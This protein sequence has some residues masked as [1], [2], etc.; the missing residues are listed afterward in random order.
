[1][2]IKKTLLKN[3]SLN[4]AGYIYLTIASFIS[5]PILLRNMGQELYGVYLLFSGIIPLIATLDFG[6]GQATIRY[7][8]LP[9]NNTKRRSSIWQTSFTSFFLVGLLVALIS[10]TF[11]SF[12]AS[13]LTA[14]SSLPSFQFLPLSIAISLILL[15]N[16]L[17]ISL[18]TLIQ[19]N[20][21]FD[22]YNLRVLIVGTG[23][24]LLTA[25]IS[26]FTSNLII[27]FFSLFFCHFLTFL[28]FLRYVCRHFSF[29]LPR[30]T[31]NKVHFKK[32]FSFGLRQFVG[33]LAS[34]INTQAS[35]YILGLSLTVSVVPIFSVPQNVIV[36]G[37]GVISQ[38]TLAFFPL[39]ASLITREKIKK[40]SRLVI[41]IEVLV[42]FI[43]ILQVVFI[44]TLGDDVLRI[45][46]NNPG[47]V[48]QAYPV[49]K[50]LSWYFLLTAVT[51]IPTAVFDSIN[52]PQIPSFFA[53]LTTV[54][55]LGSMFYLIP[56][57]G[58]LGAAYAYVFASIITVPLFLIVFY[59]VFSRYIKK[60]LSSV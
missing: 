29:S 11:F 42:L 25:L 18:M 26:T 54:L 41:G 45:W 10:F 33:N 28:I 48:E 3:T 57:F 52:R 59:C 56:R 6:L 38:L 51:P 39:S 2:S 32:L 30:P 47:F 31:L 35:K 4:L 8:S 27:I 21:R 34:Q 50:I 53:V 23:N 46:L 17:N 16:H 49:L 19:S 24:T 43:G 13:R 9:K 36:K 58:A 40:L 5:I 15:F 44:H 22:L 37:T 7:L 55:T 20:Q 14:F 60:T 1:M 12:F